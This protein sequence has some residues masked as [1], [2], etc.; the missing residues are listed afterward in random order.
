MTPGGLRSRRGAAVLVALFVVALSGVIVE[1]RARRASLRSPAPS[2]APPASTAPIASST[3]PTPSADLPLPACGPGLSRAETDEA[4]ALGTS[5][6]LHAQK[7]EGNFT[8]AYDW[9]T[10]SVARSD[11]GVRQAGAA[12][13]LALLHRHRPSPAT[14]AAVERALGYFERISRLTPEG[15]RY[16]VYPDEEEGSLGAVA[17][18]ALAHIDYLR[19]GA[20]RPELRAQLDEYLAMLRAAEGPDGRFVEGYDHDDGSAIGEPS[21]Y[22]EGEALL[23]FVE[24]ARH[25]GRDDLR[26]PA[27]LAAERGH[28]ANVVNA[29]RREPDSA[30]TRAYFQWSLMSYAELVESG[31]PGSDRFADDGLG[32][33]DWMM[34]VH[35]LGRSSGNEGYALEGLAAAQ[36]LARARGD[37]RRARKIECAVVEGLRRLTG[38]QVGHSLAAPFLRD[39]PPGD[40]QARGG[41]QMKEEGDRLRVDVTQHQMHALLLAREAGLLE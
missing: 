26:A 7:P 30:T 35:G 19:A 28:L 17:L 6:L 39:A 40:L 34:E 13:G 3:G 4:L 33:A 41:V 8:Y 1:A 11:N 27:L 31:W 23:A 18:V 38:W 25:L 24:A 15:R 12:W 21:P 2:A 5:F 37:A 36:A 29:R 20:K 9:R 32:L 16:V 10:R 14:G 22:A